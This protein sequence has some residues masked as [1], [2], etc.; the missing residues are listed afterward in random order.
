MLRGSRGLWLPPLTDLMKT[1]LK[2]IDTI[3][4]LVFFM[5]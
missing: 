4:L 1:F 2:E 5:R 3:F